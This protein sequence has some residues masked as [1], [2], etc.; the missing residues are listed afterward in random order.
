MVAEEEILKDLHSLSLG[1]ADLNLKQV[2]NQG[3]ESPE[4]SQL[5]QSICKQ[6]QNYVRLQQEIHAMQSPQDLN[7]FVMNITSLLHELECPYNRLVAAPLNERLATPENRL[8]LLDFLLGEL[9]AARLN[10]A[11]YGPDKR[12]VHS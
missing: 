2:V 6:L 9:Q 4:F 5:V 10:Y 7:S 3:P 11:N 1:G 8:L 12:F